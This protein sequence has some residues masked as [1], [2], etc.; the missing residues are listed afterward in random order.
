MNSDQPRHLKLRHSAVAL[1]FALGFAAGG[2]FAG[3]Q[4][5]F[6][7]LVGAYRAASF[8]AQSAEVIEAELGTTSGENGPVYRARASYR[9]T[10]Q[11]R[12]YIGKQLTLAMTDSQTRRALHEQLA[13]ALAQHAPVTIWLNPEAP[14]QAVFDRSVQWD[15]V[16][17]ALPVALLFSAISLMAGLSLF[18]IWRTQPALH[19]PDSREWRIEDNRKL[20]ARM[21]FPLLWCCVVWPI[22]AV[23][24]HVNRKHPDGGMLL[25]L[26]L[27]GVGFLQLWQELGAMRRQW[28]LG[29]TTLALHFDP[30]E[31]AVLL[32]QLRFHPAFASRMPAGTLLHAV[33]VSLRHV[34]KDHRGDTIKENILFEQVQRE[35]PLARGSSKLDFSLRKPDKFTTPELQDPQQEQLQWQVVLQALGDTVVWQ[36]DWLPGTGW[37]GSEETAR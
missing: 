25:M 16:L 1:V 8:V 27:C 31:T 7:Q 37:P 15:I 34:H 3:I 32:A 6:A 21:V 4:P 30:L 23:L 11:N 13:H 36:L 5:L 12:E 2:W 10:W 19:R 29:S 28:R 35:Q 22:S 9:Y 20:W 24:L 18:W 26:L 33:R 17:F 14:N